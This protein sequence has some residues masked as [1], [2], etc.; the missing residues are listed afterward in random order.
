M[1]NGEKEEKGENGGEEAVSAKR[2]VYEPVPIPKKQKTCSEELEAYLREGIL[3]NIDPLLY[4]K[5]YTKEYPCLSRLA[6]R[7][8]GV[9]ATSGAVERTFSQAGKILRPDRSRLLPRNLETLLFLK[10][11]SRLL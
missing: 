2:E 1:E 10:M 8:L 4:W 6:Q 3:P 7:V 5:K 11:N 9:P